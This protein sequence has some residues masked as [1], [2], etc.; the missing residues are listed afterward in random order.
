MPLPATLS[1]HTVCLRAFEVRVGIIRWMDV[2]RYCSFAA[3]ST[4]IHVCKSKK[5]LNERSIKR[6]I[7]KYF[8]VLVLAPSATESLP[9]VNTVS[10]YLIRQ[11]AHVQMQ[12]NELQCMC[13]TS[14]SYSQLITTLH[15]SHRTQQK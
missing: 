15:L 5:W 1:Q 12:I 11:S 14:I 6:Q 8:L 3:F 10:N 2:R 4:A 9:A 7:L 13:A